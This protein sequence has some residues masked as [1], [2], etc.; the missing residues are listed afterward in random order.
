MCIIVSLQ[1]SR[2]KRSHLGRDPVKIDAGTN[3]KGKFDRICKLNWKV[4]SCF[5]T[6]LKQNSGRY[7][8]HDSSKSGFQHK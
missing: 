4:V 8:D 1:T 7:L 3:K 2:I 6:V 5:P